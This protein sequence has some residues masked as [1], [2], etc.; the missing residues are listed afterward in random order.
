M[1]HSLDLV[2]LV[3][4]GAVWVVDN[5]DWLAVGLSHFYMSLADEIESIQEGGLGSSIFRVVVEEVWA[6][7]WCACGCRL[8]LFLVSEYG[9]HQV[10][11][12]NIGKLLITRLHGQDIG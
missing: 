1:E 4:A 3:A 8:L 10:G 6:R 11:V 5:S 12:V 7:S 2:N 9:L